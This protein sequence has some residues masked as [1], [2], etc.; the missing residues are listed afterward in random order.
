[1]LLLAAPTTITS[2]APRRIV[3]AAS[4]NARIAEASRLVIVL[5]GPRASR[6]IETWHAGMFGN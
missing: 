1:M 3:R 2:A 4:S 5:F 6:A